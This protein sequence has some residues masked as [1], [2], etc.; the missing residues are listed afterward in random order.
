MA[1]SPCCFVQAGDALQDKA[2]RAAVVPDADMLVTGDAAGWRELP[3]QKT[4][5]AIR[6]D[7]EAKA[8]PGSQ[9]RTMQARIDKFVETLGITND[10]VVAM[11]ASA[12]TRGLENPG[13]APQGPPNT[14]MVL[15][16]L[17][18]VV[19]LRV[20]KPVSLAKIRLALSNA[21]AE[22][23]LELMFEKG[24][25]K[26]ASV[27]SVV[28]PDQ[29]GKT[30]WL[31][32]ELT[33]A[34]LDADTGLYLGTDTGVK[35][36]VDR[37]AADTPAQLSPGM[38]AAQAA[39]LPEALSSV[40]F[41]PSDSMRTQAKDRGAKMQ[42]QNPMLAGAMQS[43]GGLQHVVFGAKGSDRIAL[44]LGAAFAS[45]AD[46]QQMKMMVD[47]M[48]L[49]M[50]K[51]MLMQAVGHPI[52]MVESLTSRQEGATMAIVADLTEEDLRALADL[53]LKG[54]QGVP[55]LPG[56]AGAGPVG[57]P[58]PQPAAPGGN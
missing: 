26:G 19:G 57:V 9:A 10:D 22:Q 55:G 16:R 4:L 42:A 21:A 53:S 35:A 50:G 8:P 36:A 33:V 41:V 56:P 27:L 39:A 30:S 49:G 2:L 52:P 28:R 6:A 24:D 47:A 31:P 17:G 12:R 1:L 32:R 38:T 14:Q 20:A 54:S 44:Q 37:F 25:Y 13:G 3:I 5:D 51:M 43:L 58:A 11:V 34:L 45:A 15:Q 7:M 23:G 18:L 48:V 29:P 46:A 40:F